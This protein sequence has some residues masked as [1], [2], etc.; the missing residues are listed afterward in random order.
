MP[1]AGPTSAIVPARVGLAGNPSDGYGGAVLA[2]IVEA[3]SATVTVT[4][5]DGELRIGR[6]PHGSTAWATPE[7]LATEIAASGHPSAHRVVTAALTALDA[8][9]G[10]LPGVEIA[11]SS[12]IPP[13]VGLA[14]SSAIAVATI[15]AVAA[16]AG[17]RLD[18]RVVASLALEAEVDGLGIAAGWQDRIVQAHRGAV[19]VDTAILT[20]RAGRSVPAVRPLRELEIDAVVGWR[21]EDAE[22]SGKYH[23]ALRGR[24]DVPSVAAG[25]RELAGL[26]RRA[27]RC[28]SDGDRAG[29]LRAVD[30]SWRLRRSCAPLRPDHDDLV[31]AVRRAGIV[32]TSPGSGGS[33]DRKSVV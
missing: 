12:T 27:A 2:A 25:M 5:T 8:H 24:A 26:A 31:E 33:V 14:G 22:D 16:S 21:C 13:S 29:L 32:A 3:F 1:S 17:R 30:D 28:A 20:N 19:L 6:P 4:P 15:E 23:G 9:L 7:L 10:G 18:P 11:W